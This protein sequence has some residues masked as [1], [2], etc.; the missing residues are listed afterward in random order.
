MDASAL[1]GRVCRLRTGRPP[2]SLPAAGA[3]GVHTPIERPTISFMISVVP[4]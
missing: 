2:G 3:R 4:P 1:T